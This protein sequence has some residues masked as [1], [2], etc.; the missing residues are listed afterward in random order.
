MAVD[1]IGS[2]SVN[3]KGNRYI[4]V[5]E[6]YFTKWLAAWAI[7]NQKAKNCCKQ[8]I[9]GDISPC[10]ISCMRIRGGSLVEELCKLL[11]IE[12]SHTTP[13]HLQR[14]GE[15]KLQNFGYVGNSSEEP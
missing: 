12:K 4:L 3:E 6:D 13:Y 8:I 10:P 7:P 9:G 15:S 2:F 1:I 14:D 11:Q 5:A